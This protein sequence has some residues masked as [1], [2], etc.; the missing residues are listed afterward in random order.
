MPP[1]SRLHP[2]LPDLASAQTRQ[3]NL[4]GSGEIRPGNRGPTTPAGDIGAVPD[5]A[6]QPTP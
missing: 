3:A 6:A 5:A 2:P 1:A 4:E